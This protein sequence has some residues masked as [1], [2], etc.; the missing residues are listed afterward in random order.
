MCT[1]S[2]AGELWK[3][4]EYQREKRRKEETEEKDQIR[5]ISINS[6]GLKDKRRQLA[7]AGAHMSG[8]G[9]GWPD[10]WGRAAPPC[11]ATCPASGTFLQPTYGVDLHRPIKSV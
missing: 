6:K 3:T 10:M 2:F 4:P 5:A 1:L 8:C 9:A 11:G 7:K